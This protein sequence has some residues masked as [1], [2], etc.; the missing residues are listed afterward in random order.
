MTLNEAIRRHPLAKEL[1][2]RLKEM[3]EHPITIDRTNGLCKNTEVVVPGEPFSKRLLSS[4]ALDVMW[5]YD[6]DGDQVVLYKGW[7]H[8]SGDPVYPIDGYYEG[9][10]NPYHL[11]EGIQAQRRFE[12]IKFLIQRI[13]EA[14]NEKQ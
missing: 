8:Y 2:A 14:L 7:P 10:G 5:H 12:L 9:A 4:V 3:D 1:L 11:W 6:E 13:E